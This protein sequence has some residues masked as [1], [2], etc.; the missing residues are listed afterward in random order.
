MYPYAAISELDRQSY[1]HPRDPESVLTRTARASIPGL[2]LVAED[3]IVR[4][5]LSPS[6]A[7]SV[8]KALD[9]TAEGAA[10]ALLA[11]PTGD[12]DGCLVW[13]PGQDTPAAITP[14][15][16]TGRRLAGH[17]VL[18]LPGVDEDGARIVE[19]GFA[20]MLRKES[21]KRARDALAHGTS[22]SVPASDGEMGLSIQTLLGS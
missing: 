10:L 20:A 14:P 9:A 8:S 17:F 18:L 15:G 12:S 7:T 4:V 3:G 19:D 11:W 13:S 2:A 21:W 5:G 6:A 1:A 16:S 22:C